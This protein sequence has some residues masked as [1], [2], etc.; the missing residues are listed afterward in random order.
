MKNSF[1]KYVTVDHEELSLVDPVS[2]VLSL[3]IL[4]AS[5]VFP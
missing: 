4:Q 1:C 3:G 5:L 2:E